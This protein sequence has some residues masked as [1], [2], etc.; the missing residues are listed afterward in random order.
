MIAPDDIRK[1][2][3][4]PFTEEEAVPFIECNC[5]LVSLSQK[6]PCL[7]LENCL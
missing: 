5:R 7:N 4:N 2:S 6:K 1:F 3:I